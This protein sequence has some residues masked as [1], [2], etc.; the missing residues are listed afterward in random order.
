MNSQSSHNKLA[1]AEIAQT[2]Q[3]LAVQ[4]QFARIVAKSQGDETFTQSLRKTLRNLQYSRNQLEGFQKHYRSAERNPTG[5]F[6][7]DNL[8]QRLKALIDS[9]QQHYSQLERY[10]EA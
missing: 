3:F 5:E 9:T 8:N 4:Q 2:A 1:M 7:H 10:S 6:V